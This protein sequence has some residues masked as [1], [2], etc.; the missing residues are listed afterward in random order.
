MILSEATYTKVHER[1]AAVALPP[2]RLRGKA[3]VLRV[4]NAIGMRG[5]DWKSETTKP[6]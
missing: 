6:F 2:M 4:W 5:S 3:E 1:V